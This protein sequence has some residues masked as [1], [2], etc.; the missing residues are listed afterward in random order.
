MF[1]FYKFLFQRYSKNTHFFYVLCWYC[2]FFKNLFKYCKYP[3]IG[4][5]LF[6]MAMALPVLPKQKTKEKAVSDVSRVQSVQTWQWPAEGIIAP[7]RRNLPAEVVLS[8]CPPSQ[9]S[10]LNT[11]SLFSSFFKNTANLLIHHILPVSTCTVL[12]SQLFFS[13]SQPLWYV[14]Q[15]GIADSALRLATL[16][17][18]ILRL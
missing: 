10:C 3:N 9:T 7:A 16:T 4:N 1:M 15:T 11:F 14:F 17:F 18:H 12:S 6:Y 5:L 13:L 2:K 8:L